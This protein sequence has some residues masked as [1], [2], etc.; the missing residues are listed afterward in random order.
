MNIFLTESSSAS[1][2]GVASPP[3]GAL[4][5]TRGVRR[6]LAIRGLVSYPEF[7]LASGRRADVFAID[8]NGRIT[9]VEVKSCAADFRSDQKWPE[10]REWCDEF[11]FAVDLDFPQELI[12]D[13]CGLLIADA[14]SA[15]WLRDAP[16]H[17]LPAARRKSLMLRAALTGARRLHQLEDP[18]FSRHHPEG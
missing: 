18:L 9:I 11:Y 1:A 17:P 8:D 14:Y 10:Y 3:A 16:H 13:E 6:A 7:R 2:T 5:I 4:A 15:D 12:P